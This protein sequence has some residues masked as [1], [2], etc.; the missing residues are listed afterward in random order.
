MS[1][2]STTP[3][4]A[5]R[6]V[7]RPPA[8]G[9]GTRAHSP[10]TARTTAAIPAA[11]DPRRSLRASAGS[12]GWNATNCDALGLH[13]MEE[14]V[15]HRLEPSGAI[16]RDDAS[17]GRRERP[18][19]RRSMS[20]GCASGSGDGRS[21]SASSID[22]RSAAWVGR[23]TLASRA[24]CASICCSRRRAVRVREH[25]GDR[26]R[27]A[28]RRPR[29]ARPPPAARTAPRGHPARRAAR[30]ARA[31]ADRAARAPGAAARDTPPARCCRADSFSAATAAFMNHSTKA[32]GTRVSSTRRANSRRVTRIEVWQRRGG[33]FNHR[34]SRPR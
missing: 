17:V 23:K 2:I 33:D 7:D 11:T 18:H 19:A 15:H 32:A 29:P 14:V 12:P 22:S 25:H 20:P 6:H 1:A 21:A 27:R 4:S 9:A 24:R 13:L 26:P 34:R 8:R 31:R 28:G 3:T 10:S 16:E 30:R 5:D